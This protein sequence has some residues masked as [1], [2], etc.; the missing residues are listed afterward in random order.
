MNETRVCMIGAGNFATRRL[1]P[2]IG[3]AGGSIAGI[4]TRTLVRAEQNARRFGGTPYADVDEMLDSEEP[5]CLTMLDTFW[6]KQ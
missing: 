3:A 6:R 2:Y 1:Y 5:D 4:A